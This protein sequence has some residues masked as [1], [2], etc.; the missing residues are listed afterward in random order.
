M[1]YVS[2]A[3]KVLG[4]LLQRQNTRVNVTVITVFGMEAVLPRMGMLGVQ[5]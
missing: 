5:W 4:I 3:A 1:S 2:L